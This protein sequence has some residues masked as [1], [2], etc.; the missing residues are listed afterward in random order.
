[1]ATITNQASL[2]YRGLTRL[3]NRTVG[4]LDNGLTVDTGIDKRVRFDPHADALY[5]P[6]Q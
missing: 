3:S 4:Q 1:M 5:I 6:P 2:T